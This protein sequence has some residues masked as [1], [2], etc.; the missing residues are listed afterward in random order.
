MKG[1]YIN[2]YNPVK[3]SDNVGVEH[4]SGLPYKV[5]I[6]KGTFTEDYQRSSH[7]G[8]PPRKMN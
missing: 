8:K 1:S 5:G 2:P 4:G 6:K 7:K 3:S